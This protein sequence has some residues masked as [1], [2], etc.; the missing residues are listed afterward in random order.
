MER[1]KIRVH[2][3]MLVPDTEYRPRVN[4]RWLITS[5]PYNPVIHVPEPLNGHPDNQERM[6]GMMATTTHKEGTVYVTNGTNKPERVT[7]IIEKSRGV[8]FV[9]RF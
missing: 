8:I 5:D 9:S 7:G 6:L 2:P 3:S 4:E 1:P